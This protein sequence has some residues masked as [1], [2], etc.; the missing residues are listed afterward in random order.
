[1]RKHGWLGAFAAVFALASGAGAAEIRVLSI[2]GIK[3]ALDQLIPN[4]ESESGNKVS[5]RYEILAGQ[6][7]QL[8]SGA[9]D[10]AIFA[11]A[12]VLDLAKGGDVSPAS[13]ADIAATS[14]G[15][16]VKRGAPKPPMKTVE[17]FKDALR[18]A[19]SVTYTKESATGAH[20]TAVLAKLGLS[21]E[22]KPKLLLQPG[23]D[24]TTPAVVAG[25]AELGIVLVSDIM[26][27]PGAELVAPLPAELQNVVVQTAAVGARSSIPDAANAFIAF[28]R[29][30]T[31]VSV[32]TS[33]G[34][35]PPPA[36]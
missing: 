24:M 3:A 23:G 10:V 25:T 14:I 19:K 12:S 5:I 11:R 35:T 33:T 13:V 29:R 8:A 32:F 20:I 15:V 9:F 7:D 2:P 16:T 27:N 17:D 30:P 36:Q 28:L 4:Y 1:M 34:L 31:S 26:R 22:L 21:E 6:K 18:K